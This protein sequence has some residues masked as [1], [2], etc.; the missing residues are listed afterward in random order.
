MKVKGKVT[1]VSLGFRGEQILKIMKGLICVE[2]MPPSR[3]IAHKCTKSNNNKQKC[4]QSFVLFGKEN[5]KE[6]WNGEGKRKEGTRNPSLPPKVWLFSIKMEWEPP[7]SCHIKIINF[8]LSF[9][10]KS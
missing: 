4:I 6:C 10:H 3:K 7:S 2:A 9:M 8:K 1:W 5:K